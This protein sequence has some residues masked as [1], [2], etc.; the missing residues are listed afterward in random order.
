MRVLHVIAGAEVGGAEIF[1]LEAIEGMAQRGI[2]Q[3]VVCR[4]WP[5]ALARY[6]AAGVATYPMSFD[7]LSRCLR[8][9]ARIARLA[10]SFGADLVHAWMSRAG[11]FLPRH[12]PCPAIG[13]F[14]S[15]YHLKYFRNC[16]SFIGVTPEIVAHIVA[17]GMPPERVFLVN[18]FGTMPDCP[19]VSRAALGAPAG[20]KVALVL[21]RL[22][23][24]KGIDVFLRALAE[25]PEVFGSIAGD[26]PERASYERL[27]Q[28]LWL[29]GRVRF[30]GWRD[31]RKALLAAADLV[32][33]FEEDTP[34]ELIRAI[35]P[36]LL[37][38]GADYTLDQVVGADIVRAA[39][40]E[41]RLIPIEEGFSTSGT[42]R[43]INS[44]AP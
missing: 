11:G 1:A 12:L 20:A 26:G 35:R 33:L 5:R 39:G 44:F 3:M 23:K 27:A 8:G 41:V 14:G 22:H 28:Q 6:A 21:S 37:H 31:D 16:D 30:L 9:P 17:G 29:E 19:P 38:K 15:T 7:P 2:Q 18:T 36:D 43:R 13:W 4:P 34:E 24:I 40:G 32:V 10:R 25:V 42:I